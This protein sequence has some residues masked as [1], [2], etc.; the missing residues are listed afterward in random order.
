MRRLTNVQTAA[1]AGS[2]VVGPEIKKANAAAGLMP[3]L[4][5]PLTM[6]SALKLLVYTGIPKKPAVKIAHEF[7]LPMMFVI[8]ASGTYRI[9]KASRKKAN[10]MN[11]I[12]IKVA[13]IDSLLK[14][15]MKEPASLQ[16]DSR[17]V[18]ASSLRLEALVA[19][20]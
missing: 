12:T 19:V 15:F 20:F 9:I 18:G 10:A 17:G 3:C 2:V 4:R 7:S 8:H 6:G 1:I 14:R 16:T 11:F 5:R 13:F